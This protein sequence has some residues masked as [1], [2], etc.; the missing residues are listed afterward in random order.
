MA[1]ERSTRCADVRPHW[2]RIDD[3]RA[4]PL[5]PPVPQSGRTTHR[6]FEF[7]HARR[8]GSSDHSALMEG[9][10]RSSTPAGHRVTQTLYS[11]GFLL[12]GTGEHTF[13]SGFNRPSKSREPGRCD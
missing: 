12:R 2:L 9:P 1:A 5:R 8:M 11:P 4:N 3:L 10:R 7:A 13:T 6:P